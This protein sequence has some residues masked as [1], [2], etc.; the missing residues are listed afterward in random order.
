MPCVQHKITAK[1]NLSPNRYQWC[2]PPSLWNSPGI[3]SWRCSMGTSV[4]SFNHMDGGLDLG[5]AKA[6]RL[7]SVWSIKKG[8]NH[9]SC[10]KG[11]GSEP[12]SPSKWQKLAQEWIVLWAASGAWPSPWWAETMMEAKTEEPVSRLVPWNLSGVGEDRRLPLW[13]GKHCYLQDF[14]QNIRWNGGSW[15]NVPPC[16]IFSWME[17]ELEWY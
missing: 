4:P 5:R 11:L 17:M 16:F 13:R 3:K 15:K 7:K 8:V 10:A 9:F 1:G 12:I 6:D 2:S 14:I